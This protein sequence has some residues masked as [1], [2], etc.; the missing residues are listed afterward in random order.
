MQWPPMHAF[1]G[2]GGA[3]DEPK[4]RLRKSL[5]RLFHSITMQWHLLPTQVSVTPTSSNKNY[6]KRQQMVNIVL[7]YETFLVTAGF[8]CSVFQET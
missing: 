5:M 2:L 4:E 6:V 7:G 3:C 8:V 1:F